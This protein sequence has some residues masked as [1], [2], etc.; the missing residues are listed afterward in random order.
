MSRMDSMRSYQVRPRFILS[1][2]KSA[3]GIGLVGMV[4]IPDSR[5]GNLDATRSVIRDQGSGPRE[6]EGVRGPIR[7]IGPE[8]RRGR[9][10]VPPPAGVVGVLMD[11]V[12]H[13]PV[14]GSAGRGEGIVLGGHDRP[15]SAG[16]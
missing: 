1:G 10:E 4:L 8:R 13:R 14:D 7:G 2:M 12:A 5:C 16:R 15:R 3:S 9:G 6:G 11:G